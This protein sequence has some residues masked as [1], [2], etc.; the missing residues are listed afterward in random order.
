MGDPFKEHPLYQGKAEN[1]L[2]KRLANPWRR[3]KIGKKAR[4]VPVRG[5]E[6]KWKIPD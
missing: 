2:A 4:A 6:I 5:Q 1:D 3:V